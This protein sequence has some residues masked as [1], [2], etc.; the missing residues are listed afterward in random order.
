MSMGMFNELAITFGDTFHR[1][2]GGQEQKKP[3]QFLVIIHFC[4]E[5]HNNVAG[6]YKQFVYQVS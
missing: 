4:N 3:H 1:Q 6:S 5:F 2:K